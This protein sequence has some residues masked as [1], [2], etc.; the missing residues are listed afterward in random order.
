LN[1]DSGSSNNQGPFQQQ[2]QPL[3]TSVTE[4]LNKFEDVRING[5]NKMG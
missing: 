5:L 1:E 3:Y 2:Q 4:R